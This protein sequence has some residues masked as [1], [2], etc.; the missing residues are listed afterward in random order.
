MQGVSINIFVKTGKK[1]KN[2]LGEV[3]HFNLQGKREFKYQYLINN[4][5]NSIDWR[6]LNYSIPNYF[7]VQKNFI[8]SDKYIKGFKIDELFSVNSVGIV[9]SLDAVLIG[10]SHQE[11]INQVETYYNSKI[12]KSLIIK[13]DY[14]IFDK[15]FIYYNL[16]LI[17]R[18]RN[19]VMRHVLQKNTVL[20][21]PKQA[22]K[23]FNHVFLGNSPCDKNFIDSAG[24]FGAGNAFPLY[25]YPA[26]ITQQTI[27]QTT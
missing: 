11:L 9:T 15:R 25:L 22:I 2:E 23:G 3:K 5:I 14:R 24:Q 20:N 12:D 21:I 19:K 16:K 10:F 6:K 13:F 27:H 4:N 8:E 17:D 26:T 1:S 18:A 7:F